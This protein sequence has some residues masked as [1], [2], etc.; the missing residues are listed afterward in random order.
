MGRPGEAQLYREVLVQGR[1]ASDGRL[2]VEAACCDIRA[3]TWRA[4]TCGGVREVRASE[5]TEDA[6]TDQ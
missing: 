2:D 6:E 5:K 3:E 1:Q 4:C